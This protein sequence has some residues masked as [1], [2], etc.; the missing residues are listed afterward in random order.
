LHSVY[1]GLQIVKSFRWPFRGITAF[2]LLV[3]FLFF[4]LAAGGDVGGW[5]RFRSCLVAL[6]VALGIAGLGQEVRLQWTRGALPSWFMMHSLY[7][8]RQS[9]DEVTLER[10]RAAGHVL[11][12]V[13]SQALWHGKPGLV[14]TGDL[15]AQFKV[16]T[17]GHYPFGVVSPVH[18]Q[19]GMNEYGMIVDW[20]R[21]RTFL[22]ASRPKPHDGSVEWRNGIGPESFE[23]FAAK[24]YVG[25]VVVE[26]RWTEPMKYFGQ[27][28]DW[29]LLGETQGV[30]LFVRCVSG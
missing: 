21:G 4:R 3:V 28:P 30:T 17:V 24:T 26:N 14:F 27:S 1:A 8:D 20:E 10:L 15:G 11:S 18:Q 6:S 25:A 29:R 2:Q 5:P 23:E 13:R 19:V 12:F 16:P 22:L 9:W 7:L